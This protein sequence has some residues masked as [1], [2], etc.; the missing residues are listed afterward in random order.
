VLLGVAR[1]GWYAL[2]E[3]PAFLFP[4][5]FFG[6]LAIIAL[7]LLW[8]LLASRARVRDRILALLALVVAGGASYW[9]S[10]YSVKGMVF[11][12]YALPSAVAAF[13]ITLLL[14]ARLRSQVAIWAAVAVGAACFGGSALLRND[15]FSGDFR[16]AFDWRWKLS[17]EEQYLASL[18]VGKQAP[19]E[20]GKEKR[21]TLGAVRW[22][23]FRGPNRNGV[24]PGIKLSE[25]WNVTPPRELWRRKVGPGWSS[26]A[27]TDNLL[28]TQE[29]RGEQ[30]AVVCYDALTGAEVWSHL[31]ASR[32]WEAV[33]GAGPR[34]TPTLHDGALFAL[35]A[36]GVL[37]RLDAQTG[38][39]A[40]T[41]DLRTDAGR[42]PPIWGFASS[43]LVVDGCVMV[44]AGGTNDKGLLAYDVQSGA[45]RWGGPAGDH[46]YSSP[47]FATVAGQ[48]CVL[49]LTNTGVR[50]HDPQSGQVR[51]E[52]EWKFEGYRVVQPLIIDAGSVLLGTMAGA[53]TRRIDVTN[54][55]AGNKITERWTSQAMKPGFNDFVAHRGHLFG[56]DSTLFACI[57]LATGQKK[58]KEGRYGNGQVLLLPDGDQ[59]LV[60]SEKGELVLL[61]A[62]PEKHEE[63]AR[64]PALTGKTWNHPV[65]VGNRLYV[66]NGEEAACFEL[67][68]AARP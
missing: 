42:E 17:A 29:Q 64:V 63:R 53:G 66:R 18:E 40:W 27:A 35:G 10:H 43:P 62:N 22:P 32:F 39:V 45:L 57:D 14:L 48:A 4:V 61:R 37:C 31:Y 33:A 41:R 21:P 11:Q 5:I 54:D 34:A 3:V 9:A 55:E 38:A 65:L 24:V 8:W 6:P 28:F 23:E 15:G 16:A 44:Y 19:S 56:F 7:T 52:H 60:V 49:M 12:F 30:E 67:S 36:Q 47:Q 1:L 2:D 50:A 26:F 20:T 51:W 46:S 58:W 13:V 68:L 59:L 25:D